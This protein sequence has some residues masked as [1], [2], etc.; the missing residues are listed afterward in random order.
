MIEQ[1]AFLASFSFF[2][3]GSAGGFLSYLDQ[4]GVFSYVL[5]FLL[6]FALVFVT[7]SG[8]NIFK[9]NKGVSAVIAL[10]VS[11]LSLQFNVVSLFFSELFP[12]VGVGLSVILAILILLGLFLDE[13]QKW[14]K[15]ML[16]GMSFIVL[17][18]VLFQSSIPAGWY[19][20]FYFFDTQTFSW[21]FLVLVVI[22]AILIIVKPAIRRQPLPDFVPALYRHSGNQ[23]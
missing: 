20:L 10:C 15:Y 12:R 16:L 18:I 17:F 7:L 14:M 19:N 11:L 21:I 22:I 3:Q 13:D 23:P 6:I 4:L 8:M 1:T 2:G 5:P 9:E